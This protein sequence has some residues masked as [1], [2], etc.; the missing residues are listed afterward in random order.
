[1]SEQI[2]SSKE[3]MMF[4]GID[5]SKAALD[6]NEKHKVRTRMRKTLRNAENMAAG[7]SPSCVC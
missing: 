5:V 2:T 7:S 6:A 1:M 4:I 3:E